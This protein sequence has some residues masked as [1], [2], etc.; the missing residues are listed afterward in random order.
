MGALEN[1]IHRSAKVLPKLL[2][3]LLNHFT[4][5]IS[6]SIS[7]VRQISLLILAFSYFPSLLSPSG[8][9][10]CC[11]SLGGD[12]KEGWC[13]L[14]RAGRWIW[15]LEWSAF[16]GGI[17]DWGFRRKGRAKGGGGWSRT[18][19]M[20]G[21]KRGEEERGGKEVRRQEEIR[22]ERKNTIPFS[23]RYPSRVSVTAFT[24]SFDSLPQP[25]QNPQSRFHGRKILLVLFVNSP[26]LVKNNTQEW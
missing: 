4:N 5:K 20:G 17:L 9:I 23:L 1:S 19:K 24:D 11:D 6:A 16:G 14:G 21:E 18:D 2:H 8:I 25:P 15:I 3:I 22:P 12:F 7:P 13:T 10:T 26:S